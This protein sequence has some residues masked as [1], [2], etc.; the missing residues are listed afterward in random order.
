MDM[1]RIL[2]TRARAATE[3]DLAA[4]N[5]VVERAVMTWRLP[6]RVKRLA[7]P[8]YR[9]QPHDFE[10]MRL[11]VADSAGLGITGVAALEEAVPRDLPTGH[12]GLLLHGLYVD[13]LY[14]GEGI[15]GRLL[16]AALEM[17]RERRLD[18]LLVKAQPEAV[19]FFQAMGMTRLAS[20]DRERDYPHR[21]W[22]PADARA[23]RL[24]RRI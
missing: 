10:H 9:Y 22:R 20:R 16:D 1:P 15:G 6:D 2:N 12:S 5:T 24:A 14:H 13:P 18:G 21:F 23:G 19:D 17:V 11:L 3:A 8:G 7:L 4:I